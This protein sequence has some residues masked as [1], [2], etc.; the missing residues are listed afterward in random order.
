MTFGTLPSMPFPQFISLEDA[1]DLGKPYGLESAKLCISDIFQWAAKNPDTGAQST[2]RNGYGKEHVYEAQLLTVFM[3]DTF[4]P[5][6]NTPTLANMGYCNWL[7]TFV[8]RDA[9][10]NMVANQANSLF[11][12]VADSVMWPLPQVN[13]ECLTGFQ[14]P[15]KIRSC[16]RWGTILQEWMN[17]FQAYNQF[18]ATNG[19]PAFNIVAVYRAWINANL[20]TYNQQSTTFLTE[21]RN[22]L[23]AKMPTNTLMLGVPLACSATQV[24][25]TTQ[26]LNNIQ[27]PAISWAY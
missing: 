2:R 14:C 3:Q 25:Y 16:C 20:Q 1:T 22:V 7:K 8:F 5:L 24:Q 19:V 26:Q 12:D 18:L 4:M 27:Y 17:F 6:A 13:V 23:L 15:G 9:N 21:A 10:L 11:K